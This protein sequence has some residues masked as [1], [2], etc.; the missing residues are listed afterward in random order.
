MCSVVHPGA[1]RYTSA[2]NGKHFQNGFHFSRRHSESRPLRRNVPHVRAQRLHH[3]QEQ[4]LLSGDHPKR[5]CS[6]R[7][8]IVHS[9]SLSANA[10]R[11][12]R[13]NQVNLTILISI[14]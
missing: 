1:F 10:F 9:E 6:Y 3:D 14:Q 8:Y 11:L 4:G 5:L 12:H 13:F 2:P 7:T